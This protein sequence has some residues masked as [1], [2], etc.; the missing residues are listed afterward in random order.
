MVFAVYLAIGR[1]PHGFGE[2][3]FFFMLF[4]RVLDVSEKPLN[5]PLYFLWDLFMITVAYSLVHPLFRNRP[6]VLLAF[7]LFWPLALSVSETTERFLSGNDHS[8]LPRAD[9]VFYY[10][11]GVATY[12]HKDVVFRKGVINTLTHPLFLVGIGIFVFLLSRYMYFSGELNKQDPNVLLFYFG[13]FCKGIACLFVFASALKIY[14][15]FNFVANRKII[16]R[17]FCTHAITLYFL[18]IVIEKVIGHQEY[19]AVYIGAYLIAILGGYIVH[20]I[21]EY[22]AKITQIKAFR[23]I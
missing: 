13:C 6:K 9:L 14:T 10:L 7:A 11:L 23:Y 2:H 5:Y 21:I 4:E 22:L 15:K 16:F 3:S 8:V 12:Q 17:V 19:L 20:I 1:D 18:N